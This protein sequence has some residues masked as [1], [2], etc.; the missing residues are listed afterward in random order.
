MATG[1]ATGL[2]LA[3]E[4]TMQ[5]PR[6]IA[7]AAFAVTLTSACTSPGIELGGWSADAD[8]GTSPAPPTQADAG[9]WAPT[10]DQSA[11][12]P[13]Q[14]LSGP[15]IHPE[16][17]GMG[18]P[19]LRDYRLELQHQGQLRKARV[20]IPPDYDATKPFALVINT[21]GQSFF[22]PVHVKMTQMN[23]A[24]DKRQF[25]TVAPQGTGGLLAGYNVG[26]QPN[27]QVY[28]GIDDVGF[29]RTIIDELR[30]TLCIDPRMIHC[31]GFS[32]GGSFCYRLGC[33]M[34]DRVASIASVSG[35]DGSIG[36]NPSR[37]VALLHIHGTA[38]AFAGYQGD[39]GVNKGAPASV[40]D[41]AKRLGCSPAQQLTLQKGAVTCKTYNQNC[42]QGTEA[43][44]CTVAGGT[45]NWPGGT[46]WMLGGA[47]NMDIDASAMILDFFRKHPM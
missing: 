38:D 1:G 22:A 36:C 14:G 7:A 21:H 45:H 32:I 18:V 8:A 17:A 30:K 10:P 13:D 39:G 37:P 11:E 33:D 42:Q 2:H 29:V 25:I 9:T 31:A 19:A 41:W 35:P 15:T 27:A 46:G 47:I 24:A 44:L 3:F 23:V 12:Q 26:N 43:T 16:C 40:A 5:K 20:H 28:A 6:F 34:A 4:V